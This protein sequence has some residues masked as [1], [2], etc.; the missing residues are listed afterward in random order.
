MI[1]IHYLKEYWSLV[2]DWLTYTLG[3]NGVNVILVSTLY[4]YPA[5]TFTSGERRCRMFESSQCHDCNSPLFVQVKNFIA[6]SELCLFRMTSG[7]II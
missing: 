7:Q 6:L 2:S 1:Q 4:Y 5:A 3:N